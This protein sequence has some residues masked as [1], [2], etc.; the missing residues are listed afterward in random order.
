MINPIIV[1]N[2]K[3][4][5]FKILILVFGLSSIVHG[6]ESP[7]AE[8]M[9]DQWVK[10]ERLIVTE[11][12]EWRESSAH[13][14]QLIALYEK[15]LSLLNEELSKAGKNAV[16]IDEEAESLKQSIQNSEGARLLAIKYLTQ[17]KP[18]VENL[19]RKLPNTLQQQLEAQSFIL[20]NDVN[21]ATLSDSL[22]AIIKIL[23]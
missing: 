5:L 22:Q 4:L 3:F 8:A 20:K 17:L 12:L 13:S 14:Q 21:N 23:Q 18:R 15:E 6:Q 19:Y 7:S 10:T 9:I 2:K 16:V 1:M 11:E